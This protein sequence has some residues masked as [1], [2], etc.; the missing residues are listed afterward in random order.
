MVGGADVVR[1]REELAVVLSKVGEGRSGP[2]NGG[3]SDSAAK[4]WFAGGL[5]NATTSFS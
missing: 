2:M 1:L 3:G 4:R 5:S